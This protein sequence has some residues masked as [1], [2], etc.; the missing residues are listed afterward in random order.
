MGVHAGTRVQ[1][2]TH[3]KHASL[4]AGNR[5]VL[6]HPLGVHNPDGRM[7]VHCDVT[8]DPNQGWHLAIVAYP[9]MEVPYVSTSVRTNNRDRNG[10]VPSPADS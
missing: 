2:A 4:R 7:L 10:S 5:T 6:V 9:R 8:T 3:L 1:N